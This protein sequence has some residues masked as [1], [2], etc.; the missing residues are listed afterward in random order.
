M[1]GITMIE[2]LKESGDKAFGLKVTGRVTAAEVEAFL[3]QLEFAIKDRGKRTLGILADLSG[4][5]GADW[6]ARWDEIKLLSKYSD[7]IARVAVVGAGK[8]ED[9][10]AEILAGT[11]LIQAET[12][13]YPSA[14]I[15]HA[16]HWVKTGDSGASAGRTILPKGSLMAGYVPEYLEV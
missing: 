11:V 14:D 2:R 6:K 1:K 13:Y 7:H 15:L 4:M 5:A 12:R 3:P 10:K 9:A 8:W 16:W